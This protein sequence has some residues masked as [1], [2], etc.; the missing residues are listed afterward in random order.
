MPAFFA[1]GID[2]Q[3]RRAV[4]DRTVTREVRGAGD[5]HAKTND[6]HQFRQVIAERIAQLCEQAQCGEFGGVGAFFVGHRFTESADER[7][8]AVQ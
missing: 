7:R 1:E 2:Q 5:E 3:V 4:S 6:A 8:F